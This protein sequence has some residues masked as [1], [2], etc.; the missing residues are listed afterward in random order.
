VPNELLITQRVENASLADNKLMMT[1]VVQVAYGSDLTAVFAAVRDAVATV[2]RVV[3]D[4]APNVYLTNFA[5]D[6]LELTV[7][8]WIGDPENGQMAARSAV[9]LVILD[10]LNR[11]GVEIPFPQ[12]VVRHV[13]VP[14]VVS[15]AAR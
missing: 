11:L 5:G 3:Q 6:G 4:P 15:S 7:A 14:E 12:R 9:N 10:T 1:S 2:P 13:G 8:F